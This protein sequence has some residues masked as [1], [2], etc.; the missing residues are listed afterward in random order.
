M[1][2]Q[3]RTGVFETNSSSTHSLTIYSTH[4]SYDNVYFEVE[5]N[6]VI[7]RPGEFGWGYDKYS[8]PSIKLEYAVLLALSSVEYSIT[9]EEEFYESEEFQMLNDLI[10]YNTPYSGIILKDFNFKYNEEWSYFDHEGYI[11][12]QS[13]MT[14]NEFLSEYGID[15]EGFIFGDTVLII[16]NDNH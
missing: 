5:D 10:K 15:L 2:R 11:D 3:I 6:Y 8:S 7:V 16:D 9:L 4:C 14:L 1:K 13:K 12:H